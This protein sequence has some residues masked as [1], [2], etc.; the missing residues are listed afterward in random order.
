MCAERYSLRHGQR[1]ARPPERE[2]GHKI[3][4]SSQFHHARSP[5]R[6]AQEYATVEWPVNVPGS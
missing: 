2:T 5:F 3:E 6:I 1:S 4:V